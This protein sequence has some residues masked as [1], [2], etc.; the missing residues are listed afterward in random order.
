MTIVAGGG[1]WPVDPIHTA[2]LAATKETIMTI[3]TTTARSTPHY[4][5][6]PQYPR[7]QRVIN[8]NHN[9]NDNHNHNDHS[10][11]AGGGAKKPAAAAGKWGQKKN[12]QSFAGSGNRLS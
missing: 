10:A 11:T 6:P 7:S 8:H 2:L 9:I 3:T 4:E 5:S 12:F 1:C